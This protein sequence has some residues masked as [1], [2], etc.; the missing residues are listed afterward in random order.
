MIGSCYSQ[1]D[2]KLEE[3]KIKKL[4]SDLCTYAVSGN[5][6]EYSKLMKQ[7][8]TFQ[9][10]HP[11]Q[12]HWLCG[13]QNFE[14]LYEPIIKRGINAKFITKD[15]KIFFSKMRMWQGVQLMP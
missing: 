3:Q 15:I 1:P 14:K 10:I 4:Y 5:W 9:L 2:L 7:D 8:S 12:G 6:T 13:Y 11:D